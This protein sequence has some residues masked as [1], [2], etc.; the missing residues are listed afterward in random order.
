[1]SE[2]TR[3]SRFIRIVNDL[4]KG[5][6][7]KR[8]CA[9]W[10]LCT[11]M[12]IALPA[13]TFTVLYDFCSEPGCLDGKHPSPALVQGADGNLY[14]CGYSGG[15]YGGGNAFKL[16]PDGQMTIFYN[17][18]SESQCADGKNPYGDFTLAPDGNFYGTTWF[19]GLKNAGVAFK[20]TPGGQ[21]TTLYTFCSQSGCHDGTAPEG[22]L[23]MDAEQ[24][25][26]GTTW[27][28]GAHGDHGT[29]FQLSPGGQL[30]TLYSFC[31]QSGC[32]DGYRP[33]RALVQDSHWNFYGTAR[34]GGANAKGTL[35]E[36]TRQGQ[37][38]T[39]YS[40]CSQPSCTD[41][42]TP[43]TMVLASDGD[44]YGITTYGGASNYGTFFKMS[45]GGRPV[46]LHSFC[47]LSDCS[48]G[49]GPISLIE[50]SDRNFYGFTEKAEGHHNGTVFKITPTGVLTTLQTL[51][52]DGVCAD[53]A[54]SSVPSLV[55][56][57]SGAFYGTV[58]K[59]GNS[60]DDGTLFSL[61]AGLGR[62][63]KAVPNIGSV[64]AAVQILGTDLTGALAVTFNGAPAAFTVVSPTLIATTVPTGATAGTVRVVT[65][66]GTL[67]SNVP[68]QIQ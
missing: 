30:K 61:S 39:L 45:P 40:F 46:V 16:T 64:G 60:T 50:G 58:G 31:P 10:A 24:N 7:G 29:I 54:M 11:A 52:Q 65:P 28:G 56:H 37:M 13:Q 18:C 42:A 27:A 53:G 35:W 32:P 33:S 3:V 14:G 62:L 8:A 4:G 41:G 68:F 44:F 43:V 48:D 63:V 51:C 67:S 19:G 12:A 17:F 34:Y 22:A 26:Y 66:S 23:L 59:G 20:L 25:L 21:M 1:M 6:W 5:I 57:T 55:Q 49:G 38:I 15:L 36:R 9:V 47:S 2:K